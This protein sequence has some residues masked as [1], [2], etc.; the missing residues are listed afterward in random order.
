MKNQLIERASIAKAWA[1]G[2]RETKGLNWKFSLGEE[3][4][5]NG[6]PQNVDTVLKTAGSSFH[7]VS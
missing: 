7:S 2:F 5:M 1:S 4:F 6:L 3:R